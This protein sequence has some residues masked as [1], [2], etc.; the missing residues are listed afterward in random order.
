VNGPCEIGFGTKI[1]HFTHVQKGTRIANMCIP[2]QNVN[3]GENV[4]IGYNVKI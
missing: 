3:V 2:G 4:K 1:W